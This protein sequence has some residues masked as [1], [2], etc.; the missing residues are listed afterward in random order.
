MN[1]SL[2]PYRYNQ[3]GFTVEPFGPKA[4]A[5]RSVPVILGRTADPV[6]VKEI[7][8]D[9]IE[10]GI[11]R[12]V[13]SVERLRR[14]VACRGAVKA[15][16]V[17]TPDQCEQLIRQLRKMQNPFTCPHGRP[18]MVVFTKKKLDGLFERI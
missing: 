11:S 18:T 4:W 17:C 8:S 12:G 15:G 10:P 13:D 3:E 2:P 7:V 6:M 14:I 16:A 9:L 5:I 1:S